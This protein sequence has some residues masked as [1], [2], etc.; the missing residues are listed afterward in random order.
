MYNTFYRI[1][2]M[3]FKFP[4]QNQ[5]TEDSCRVVKQTEEEMVRLALTKHNSG[6]N[7]GC[8]VENMKPFILSGLCL[9]QNKG[10][11]PFIKECHHID[12]RYTND[13]R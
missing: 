1:E 5:S 2:D 11:I 6:H 12:E 4:L 7:T 9:T 8:R 10:S 3:N 13:K